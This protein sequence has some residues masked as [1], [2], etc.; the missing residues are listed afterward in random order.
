MARRGALLL[1]AVVALGGCTAEAPAPATPAGCGLVSAR[2]VSGL[3][4]EDLRA[5]STGSR[6]ALGAEGGHVRCVTRGDGAVRRVTVDVL[7]HPAPLSLDG[8]PCRTGWVYAGTPEAYSPACQDAVGDGGRTTLLARRG[9]YVVTV[10]VARIDRAWAGDPEAALDL[11]DS[12]GTR[13][14]LG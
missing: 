11:A 10:V 14:E 6:A 12:A 2:E 7:R 3:M 8:R 4:G 1:A 13:L 5:R 9:D